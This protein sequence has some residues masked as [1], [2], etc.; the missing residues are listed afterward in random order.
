MEISKDIKSLVIMPNE[1]EVPTQTV[2]KQTVTKK[3]LKNKFGNDKLFYVV[4]TLLLIFL[5]LLVVYP[6]YFLI[7]ASISDPDLIFAGEVFLF[8]KGINFAGYQRLFQDKLIWTGYLNTIIYTVLGTMLSVFLTIPAG[9]GLSRAKMPCK[10]L[11]M[12]LF[13]VPMFFGGGLIPFY[14]V[15]SSM[16]MV[17]TPFA[18]IIPGALSVWNVFM[19]K[20]FFQSNIPGEIV[21]AAEMDGAGLMKMFFTIVMPL[22]KPIIAVMILYYAVGQWNS[23]FNAL[24]FLSKES[25]YPLQLVLRE[26]LITEESSMGGGSA[27][28]ILEQLK[29]AN[30]VKYSS[31]IISSLP[32]ICLYPLVQKYFDQGILVGS[33]KS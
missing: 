10:K 16:G 19:T 23:Y 7:I 22:A 15:V 30:S 33:I 6:L 26:I 12:W 20:A 5:T 18:M 17:N 13:I 32:I 29:L 24:I 4:N 25:L 14:L 11:I 27:E 31:I 8:P 28:T 3:P 1:T 9:W 2:K 21:E